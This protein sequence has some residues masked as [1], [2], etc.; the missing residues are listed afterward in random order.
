MKIFLLLAQIFSI[1]PID[2]T[3]ID[4]KY[5]DD[6]KF[7]HFDHIYRCDVE[8]VAFV[9]DEESEVAEVRG[10]HLEG[11]SND[12]VK[13]V[14]FRFATSLSTVPQGLAKFFPSL[15]GLL[16]TEMEVEELSGEELG[17]YP[18]LEMF[19][20]ELSSKLKRISGDFFKSTPKMEIVNFSNNR[21]LEHVGAGLLDGLQNLFEAHFVGNACISSNATRESISKLREELA[22]KCP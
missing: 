5:L 4:C 6:L 20:F 14:F 2:S 7:R 12:D 11:K 10:K 18:K 15:V 13:M 22:A 17:S 1:V 19:G 8:R 16:F 3:T 9:E 21:Q